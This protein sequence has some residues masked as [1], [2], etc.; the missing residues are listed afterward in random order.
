MKTS[1]PIDCDV[2]F[3]T[4]QTRC[5]LHATTRADT[6]EL[7]ESVKDRTIITNIVF[8]LLLGERVH[9][10]GCDLLKEVDVLVGMELGH[11][12]TGGRFGALQE[13]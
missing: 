3:A 1:S 4:V 9:I 7:E 5:T 12:M 10:V 8:P 13:I 2:A 11:L 6:T